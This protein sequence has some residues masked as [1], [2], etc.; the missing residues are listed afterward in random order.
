MRKFSAAFALTVAAVMAAPPSIGTVSAHGSIQLDG[1][2][3]Y[4]NGTVFDGTLIE[5]EKA[6]TNLRLERG[7]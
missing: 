3:V 2:R 1:S 6:T 4:G 7:I 5:T